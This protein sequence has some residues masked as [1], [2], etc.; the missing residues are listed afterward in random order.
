M[1]DST[2]LGNKKKK[3]KSDVTSPR[4]GPEGD[5][6]NNKQVVKMR[7]TKSPKPAK[8]VMSDSE[9]IS[10]SSPP[11]MKKKRR[12]GSDIQWTES[13][14]EKKIKTGTVYEN[15]DVMTDN[16]RKVTTPKLKKKQK[17]TGSLDG[18]WEKAVEKAR[19]L[20]DGA[21][22]ST[23]DNFFTYSDPNSPEKKRQEKSIENKKV[24]RKKTMNVS[25]PTPH[26]KRLITGLVC[27]LTLC[28]RTCFQYQLYEGIHCSMT[29]AIYPSIFFL[30]SAVAELFTVT[31]V[32]V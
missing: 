1:D 8:A 32:Y 24:G 26:Q 20:P 3:R 28:C 10:P 16:S 12:S 9:N 4:Y 5:S 23:E 15:Q 19:G 2:V 21:T 11:S 18:S 27:C 25:K 7:K 14:P 31:P 29:N 30:S 6:I 17:S 13:S 22:G